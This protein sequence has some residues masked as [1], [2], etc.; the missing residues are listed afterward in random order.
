MM[1]VTGWRW[2]LEDDEGSR[3][4]S[5]VRVKVAVTVGTEGDGGDGGGLEGGGGG[6]GDGGDEGG[7]GGNCGR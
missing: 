4:G 6:K 5:S 1:V 2:R 3:A 7:G